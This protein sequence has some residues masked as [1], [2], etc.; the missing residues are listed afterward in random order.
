ML[1]LGNDAH[2]NTA[3]QLPIAGLREGHV[4]AIDSEHRVTKPAIR[5][6]V[7]VVALALNNGHQFRLGPASPQQFPITICVPLNAQDQP[8]TYIS[9]RPILH[10]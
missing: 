6:S 5:P 1:Q 10:A 2:Q 8:S 7:H 9:A 3:A 4:N